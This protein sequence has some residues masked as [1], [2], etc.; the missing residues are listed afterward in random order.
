L[1]GSDGFVRGKRLDCAVAGA[2]MREIIVV[3]SLALWASSTVPAQPA[4]VRT[5]GQ[6]YKSVRVLVRAPHPIEW[7]R[8][9]Y[10]ATFDIDAI[11]HVKP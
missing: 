2:I 1:G 4:S 3:S 11:A 6:R 5:A 7:L 8:A 9:D 10:H